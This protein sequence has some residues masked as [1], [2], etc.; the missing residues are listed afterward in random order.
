MLW[1]SRNSS[2][3]FVEISGSALKLFAVAFALIRSIS[4]MG[5]MW[6]NERLVAI[7]F[8]PLP[9]TMS[10]VIGTTYFPT[11]KEV[12]S[13]STC[14]F[15]FNSSFTSPK[16]MLFSVSG[17]TNDEQMLHHSWNLI[18]SFLILAESRKVS[19]WNSPV[20]AGVVWK[21]QCIVLVELRLFF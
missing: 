2:C 15:C 7:T 19:F 9:A 6:P 17:Q 18:E 10:I 1:H 3:K 4:S 13:K 5:L 14:I 16:K 21:K 11:T 8:S 20:T 12:V